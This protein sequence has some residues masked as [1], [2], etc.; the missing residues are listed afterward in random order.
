MNRDYE[1]SIHGLCLGFGVGSFSLFCFFNLGLIGLGLI[2]HQI[3]F[4]VS[5]VI[6]SIVY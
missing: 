2:I 4:I 6:L 3:L 1:L 5:I